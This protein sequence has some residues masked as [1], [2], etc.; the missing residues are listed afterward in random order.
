MA[1]R[2]TL[3]RSQDRIRRQKRRRRLR[4]VLF[5]IAL[6]SSPFWGEFAIKWSVSHLI[7]SLT[8]Y[9]VRSIHVTGEKRLSARE[10]IEI[11]GIVEGTPLFQVDLKSV[12]EK[13][14]AH[15]WVRTAIPL[16]RFPDTIELQI[17][18]REPVAWINSSSIWMISADGI[19]LPSETWTQTWDLPLLRVPWMLSRAPGDR[20]S[21]YRANALLAQI[22]SA[23]KYAPRIWNELSEFFWKDGEIWAIFQKGNIE[24]RLGTG[25]DE[26]GWKS[27]DKLLA[28]LQAQHKIAN[29]ESIDLRFADR[30]V[31]RYGEQQN[32]NQILQ[33]NDEKLRQS[34]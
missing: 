19:L 24:L 12:A 10:L 31:V 30:I 26:I 7:A 17:E 4:K 33:D 28:Q 11:S 29:V 14:E 18:E 20:L 25:T 1:S 23:Q 2:K 9:R 3:S 15:P 13:L 32:S 16:R 8:S 34:S 27:L 5:F 22:S 6:L 21:E